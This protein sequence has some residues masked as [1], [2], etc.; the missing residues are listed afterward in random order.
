MSRLTW[1]LLGRRSSGKSS[2]EAGRGVKDEGSDL[3]AVGLF[4]E[5]AG[6]LVRRLAIAGGDDAAIGAGTMAPRSLK[7]D[8]QS[9]RLLSESG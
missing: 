4:Q 7:L 3:E 6:R 1:D 8:L 9:S 2:G 5:I